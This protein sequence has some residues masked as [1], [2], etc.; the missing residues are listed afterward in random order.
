MEFLRLKVK[1]GHEVFEESDYTKKKI[2]EYGI[3]TL[4]DEN[5]I[6]TNYWRIKLRRDFLE[7]FRF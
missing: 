6:W 2:E 7:K 1:L 4:M 5:E 3:I